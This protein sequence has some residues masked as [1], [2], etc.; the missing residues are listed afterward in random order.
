M[1]ALIGGAIAVA[2]FLVWLAFR[3]ARKRGAAEV[4]AGQAATAARI[5]EE[6]RDAPRPD[7]AD[8]DDVLNRLR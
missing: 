1:Y 3:Q 7:P 8:P 5:I 6:Q 4:R 2:L